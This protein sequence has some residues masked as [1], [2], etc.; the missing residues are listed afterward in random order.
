VPR[1]TTDPP[2]ILVIDDEPDARHL[3]TRLLERQGHSVATA[4][5][6]WHALEYLRSHGLP[7]L[8]LLEMAMPE[9]DGWEFLHQ[10]RHRPDLRAV[11]VV[12]FSAVADLQGC[13]PRGLGAA[14]V[15]HKPFEMPR[16]LD[17][18]RRYCGGAWLPPENARGV[19]APGGVTC[20]SIC[21]HRAAS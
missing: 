7:R 14:E 13:D 16:V 15:L 20:P 5:H 17:V 3:L 9:M 19:S 2:D 10:R 12:I 8:I 1:D 21:L 6:G 18:A 11:P 4:A